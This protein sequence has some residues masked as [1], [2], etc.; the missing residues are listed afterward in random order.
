M[1]MMKKEAQSR[2]QL[3]R[4]R[5]LHGELERI[6]I[7]AMDFKALDR[8]TDVLIKGIFGE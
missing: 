6:Y 8:Q 4:A 5:V 1:D 3:A 7:P 2:E